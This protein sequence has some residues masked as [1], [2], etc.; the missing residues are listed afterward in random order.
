LAD[1]NYSSLLVG[2][3]PNSNEGG[4]FGFKYITGNNSNIAINHWGDSN[5]FVIKKGGNIGVGLD[6]PSYSLQLNSDSA[7]KPSSNTWTIASDRRIKEDIVPADLDIC[8]NNIKNLPLKYFTWASGVYTEKQV[9]DRHVLGWIAQDVSGVF[10]KA[11]KTFNFKNKELEIPDCLSLDSS[12]II[13]TLY[14]AV[15]KL[16]EK[17]EYLETRLSGLI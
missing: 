13:S 17:V 10:P 6:N 8:Y 14:G 11:V 16:M 9:S 7:A 5:S 4:L 1:G 12:Q 3:S 2:K 15:Q